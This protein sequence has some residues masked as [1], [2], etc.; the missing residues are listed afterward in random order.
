MSRTVY[1]NSQ[2]LAVHH[3]AFFTN[4]AINKGEELVYDYFPH[5]EADVKVEDS[6]KTCKC[7]ADN[8]RKYLII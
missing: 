3:I 8:C 6:K 4:R 1:I 2:N 5:Y 7:G